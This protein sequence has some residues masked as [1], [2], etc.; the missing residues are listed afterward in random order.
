V[1]RGATAF[2]NKADE[3]S[4]YFIEHLPEMTLVLYS[5]ED[6]ATW[7]DDIFGGL[8]GEFNR[9]NVAAALAVAKHLGAPE[10][11]TLSA[12]KDFQG[13]PGRME[14][15]IK[16]PFRVVVDYAHTAD[17]LEAV[18]KALRADMDAGQKLIAVL[19]SCGG[20]RDK[21][22]RPVMGEVV[23]RYADRI[24]L[25]DEDPYDETP[26][27]ILDDIEGGISMSTGDRFK[28]ENHVLKILDRRSAI[29]EAI[30]MATPGDTVVMTGKG[31]ESSIHIAGGKTIAWSERREAEEA[32]KMI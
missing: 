6:I 17:S 16:E 27:A 4:R 5:P 23:G 13:V 21:W 29:R 30:A 11:A 7:P 8:P 26:E 20:H 18:Y 14:F 2:V 3:R 28:G 9:H 25:T 1:S 32:L 12:L 24:I 10:S 22:K 15:V 19:G 31:S